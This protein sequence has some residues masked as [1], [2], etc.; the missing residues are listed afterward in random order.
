[1]P[2]EPLVK[3]RQIYAGQM[4]I[5]LLSTLRYAMG[6][7][8]YVTGLAAELVTEH[9]DM[10]TEAQRRQIVDEIRQELSIAQSVQGGWL[11]DEADHAMWKRTADELEKHIE[12]AVTLTMFVIYDHPLDMPDYFCV[13][14][15]FHLADGRTVV[16]G[17][18]MGFLQLESA[19][20]WCMDRGLG[21]VDRDPNDDAKII[22]VWI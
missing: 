21:K 8:S 12:H 1:M 20:Q 6:R 13:R 7:K 4:W 14:R 18:R 17:E 10:L 15:H 11:G 5:M 22:E 3:S 9:F 2:D 16:D 19:R